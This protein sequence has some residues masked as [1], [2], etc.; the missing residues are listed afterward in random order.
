MLKILLVKTSSMGDVINNLP[1][2]T[3]I[4]A[5]VPD[6]VIDW[7]VEESFADI[8][9]LHP[10]IRRIIPVAMRRWR[11]GL[12]RAATWREIAAFRQQLRQESYSLVLDTQG[13]MKSALITAQAQGTRCGFDWRSAWEPL[14]TLA[15]QRK[16]PV[17]PALHAVIRYRLLASQ[18][19][20]YELGPRLD[21]G[22]ETPK[23]SLPW[24]LQSPYVVLLHATSRPEKLWPADAWVQ[25]GAHFHAL[26]FTSVIPWGSERE[27]A[28]S[29]LLAERIPNAVVPPRMRIRQAAAL[30]G[31]AHL[32]VGV[33][34]GLIHLAAAL[35]KKALGI[36]CG[37]DPAANG[38]YAD[39]PVANIGSVGQSPSASEVI[40]A[41]EI[42]AQQ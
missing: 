40:A 42:L 4:L 37:S 26:G 38:L 35:K 10:G 1:V 3:D 18:A 36:F 33:D 8:P 2:V 7:V 39:T 25:V 41:I 32:V 11:K 24:L 30:L 19:F 12:W 31:G 34:T 29:R 21:Y 22:I 14:A 28:R 9:A 27:H 16:F 5:R 6:A 15:Y 17:D 20:G 23:E 13:L